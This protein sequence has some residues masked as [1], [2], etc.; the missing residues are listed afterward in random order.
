MRTFLEIGTGNVLTGLV[1]RI[2]PACR[3]LALDEPES[4]RELAG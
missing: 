3:G 2:D 1:R 4:Y